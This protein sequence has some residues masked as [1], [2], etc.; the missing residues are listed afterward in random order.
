MALILVAVIYGAYGVF[1]RM[2]G[3]EFSVFSQSWIR[4]LIVIVTVASIIFLSKNKVKPLRKQDLLWIILWLASGVGTIPL[5]FTAFNNLPIGTTYL[6]IYVTMITFGYL[7]GWILF[8]EKIN[9]L[10]IVS[11]LLAL[12]GL[13]IIYSVNMVAE[14]L[15]FFA[16]AL[17]SGA[18]TGFWNTITK[19]FSKNYSTLQL[20]LVDAIIAF[21]VSLI[22][23]FAMKEFLP[24]LTLTPAWGWI[25]VYAMAQICT[26]GL[27]VYGFKYV[28]AQIGSVILPLETFFGAMLG[29]IRFSKKCCHVNMAT[30]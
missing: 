20:I 21:I 15:P 25:V 24:A 9:A 3:E 2:I 7:S 13:S 26:V 19:K 5:T 6:L 8:K 22:A 1:I 30:H 17:G 29:F 4:S 16:I 11:I 23:F 10:K 28:E 27:I 14:K 12:V 18:L